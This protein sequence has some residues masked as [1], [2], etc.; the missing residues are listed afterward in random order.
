[1]LAE[2]FRR[3]VRP[4]GHAAWEAERPSLAAGLAREAIL[5]RC[6]TLDDAPTR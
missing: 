5:K 3:A 1:V 2:S 4:G 6:G